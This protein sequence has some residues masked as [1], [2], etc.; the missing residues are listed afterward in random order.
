MWKKLSVTL[1]AGTIAALSWAS[2]ASAAGDGPEVR[3]GATAAKAMAG[4]YGG[5]CFGQ[6]P[7][8]S[9]PI[10]SYTLKPVAVSANG[11]FGAQGWEEC[12]HGT[13]CLFQN[14]NGN[15][16][17]PGWVWKV[18]SCGRIWNLDS[19]TTNRTSSLWNRAGSPLQVF[20]G[21]DGSGYLTTYGAFGPATNLPSSWND[22]ISSVY[23]PC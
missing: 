7:T 23:A 22:R 6:D 21:S 10:G 14:S 16:N 2:P 17:S 20:D 4:C 19:S 18:P 11:G 12:L 9:T 13:A 8:P 3:A 15:A 1:A 5:S